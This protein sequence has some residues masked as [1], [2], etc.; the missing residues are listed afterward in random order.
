MKSSSFSSSKGDISTK[1]PT[2]L[3]LLRKRRLLL[4]RRNIVQPLKDDC[5]IRDDSTIL[6]HSSDSLRRLSMVCYIESAKESKKEETW[7][8][9]S[10]FW[11]TTTINSEYL[12][13]KGNETTHI[14]MNDEWKQKM[15][16]VLS[17]FLKF[18]PARWPSS[19]S[20]IYTTRFSTGH[21]LFSSYWWGKKEKYY[22]LFLINDRLVSRYSS[23]HKHVVFE[24][25]ARRDLK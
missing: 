19:K 22:H 12:L 17:N 5:A 16:P 8:S 23:K 1:Q 24:L 2:R 6:S 3:E 25:F 7:I 18:I 11:I 20:T 13:R 10:R 14:L 15:D 21:S 9:D 4:L